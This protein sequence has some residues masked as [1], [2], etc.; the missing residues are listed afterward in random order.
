MTRR[1]ILWDAQRG[2]A[3]RLLRGHRNIVWA[4]IFSAD[5][6]QLLSASLDRTL[7]LW[8]V[9]S[10]VTLGVWQGHIGGITGLTRHGEAVFSAG[11]DG[12]LRRW[13]LGP[14]AWIDGQAARRLW[15]L[16]SEP[17]SNAISLDGR[18]LAIGFA[19]GALRLYRLPEG[20]V[21]WEDAAAHEGDVQ[22]LS[23]NAEGTQLASAGL[24]DGT[25]KLWQLTFDAID[26]GAGLSASDLHSAQALD[27]T[28]A[29]GE[30]GIALR[31]LQTFD[32]HTDGVHDVAFSP[33][34]QILASASYDGR[35]GLFQIGGGPPH[36][37]KHPDPFDAHDGRVNAV[38][39]TPDGR[40]LLSAS[41]TD[42]S[43]KLWQ[44]DTTPPTLARTLLKAQDSLLWATLS[45]DGSHAAAV[46]RG[47]NVT[48][49][50]LDAATAPL[51]LP[52]H[53]Q[54]VFKAVFDPS[55]EL[56][57]T[58]SADATMRV[59]DLTAKAELF[60]LKLPTIAGGNPVPLWDF[61]FRCVPAQTPT[62][63]L[64]AVPLTRGK[65]ALYRINY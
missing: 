33:D 53:E 18:L 55:G 23:F 61:D 38:S 14:Q 27:S 34:G 21:L 57:A 31:L 2:T 19:N 62:H 32:G 5:G 29:V 1:L 65:L 54:T 40:Y 59:W 8:D 24:A 22:R 47:N 28:S 26:G 45:A 36:S 44:L 49:L 39:F 25:A 51:R 37:D 16:P 64:I 17:A 35:I 7:R 30:Q 11:K 41:I 42:R 63:C 15:D 48:V 20:E 43:L 10:G 58:V 46:G 56:L 60:N 50:P 6:T 9:D 13:S 3:L 52:G 4:P 12:T